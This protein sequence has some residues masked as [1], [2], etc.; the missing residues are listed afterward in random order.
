MKILKYLLFLIL[1]LIIAGSVYVATKDGDFQV[2][3]TKMIAAPQEMVYNEV[4]EYKNW[5]DWEPWSQEARDMVISY[6]EKTQGDG[7]GYSW[8]SE[9]MGDGHIETIKATPFSSITEKITFDTPFGESSSQIYW[10]FKEKE[11]GTQVTWGM[12]GEQSFMEKLAFSFQDQTIS[13]MMLPMF[14]KGLANLERVVKDKMETYSINVDGLTMHGGGY[15]MYTTTATKISQVEDRMQKML[16][17]VST[18]M[19]ENNIEKAG[20]PFVLYNEWNEK[21]GTAIFSAGIFTSSKVVTPMDSMILSD[22]LPN[23]KV[24]KTTLKGDYKNLKEAWDKTYK[25]IQ[26]NGLE[27]NEDTH[28]FEVYLTSPEKE[29]NPAKWITHI[30]VPVK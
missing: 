26:E 17:E 20:N 23:Q 13:E 18:Y 21:N 29:T 22:Y 1:I 3:Q 30:Y 14:D 2:E 28:P 27:I 25:Y 4:N 24:V 5:K 10:K 9:D 7:A 15:Y 16:H 19:T 8:K 11:N 6:S 12:K